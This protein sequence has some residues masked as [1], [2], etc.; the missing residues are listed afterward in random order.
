[1]TS[2]L[3]WGV[4]GTGNIARTFAKGVRA[5]KSGE[6]VAVGSRTQESA[7]K[8]ANEY[9]IAVRHAS[10]DA[11]LAD[12]NVQ[13]IYISTPHPLHAEWAIKAARAGKHILCEKPL[14]MNAPEAMTIVEACRA[15]NV[16]L[17]EAFMYRCHPQTA[18]LVELIK[19]KIIG[20]VKMIR[21]NFSFRAGFD[22]QS[23]LYNKELG[24][25]GILDVGCYTAS[26]T[27]LIVGA[28][29]GRDFA[30]PLEVRA[31]GHRG[32]SGVDEYSTAILRF[33]GDIVAQLSSGVGLNMDNTVHVFGT[34]GSLTVPD[35]WFCGASKIVVEKGGKTEEIAVEAGENLYAY[36]A[37]AFAD[38][39]QNNRAPHPAP[40]PQDSISNMLVLDKWRKAIG[41]EYSNDTLS[42]QTAPL[43]RTPLK[44]QSDAPMTYGSVRHLDKKVSR[45]VMGGMLENIVFQAPQGMAMYDDF[46]E[47][48]GNCFDTGYIYG[49]SDNV[50]G[51][52]I[53]SRGVRNEVVTL[54]KGAHSPHCNPDK[55][56]AQLLESLERMQ[57]D[58]TDLYM[59]HRDNLEVPV[60]EFIDVLNEHVKAGRIKA[61][62]G[63]NWSNERVQAANDYANSKG[64]QGFSAI[65]NNFSL[66]R[67]I[68][69]I[70]GGCIASSDAQSRAWLTQNQLAIMPWSSQARG[71]FVRG[72]R[73]FTA[74]EE[75]VRCWYS[76]DNFQRLERVR[77]MAAQRNLKPI[78]IALA[79]VLNQPFPTFPLIGPQT[80]DETRSSLNA[81]NIQ[82][83]PDEVKWL[84][85]EA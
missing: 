80:I 33:D 58:F 17:M 6:L 31:I 23:R 21:A 62:G 12:E 71:F 41:L 65:S 34:E 73:N 22:P 85:L 64:L 67:M 82:L 39:V 13:A 15:N 5:S 30:D 78:E 79:Y 26:M 76:D 69:P 51:H 2:K 16:I 84:N 14:T 4:L 40:S 54:V 11:L 7:D 75:L 61:F 37:D 53:N 68:D 19:Q 38:A 28:T 10:Y 35:P 81:L 49:S 3:K 29:L 27:R 52:W 46:F 74:D 44:V 63:S 9:S 32:E 24:G 77:E 60:A 50:L 56:S 42:G 45:V 18:K 57:M 72:D 36:E 83:S 59:M 47:R 25:G 48:G 20:D 43:S 70:W 1:M 66:A 55:L 8:F